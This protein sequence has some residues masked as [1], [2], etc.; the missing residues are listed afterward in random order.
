MWLYIVQSIVL[1]FCPKD[2][3]LNMKILLWNIKMHKCK[4]MSIQKLKCERHLSKIW[5]KKFY[6][7]RIIVRHVYF[8]AEKSKKRN[9]RKPRG[10][11]KGNEG[12][13]T[14]K[15]PIKFAA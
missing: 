14:R 12:F 9:W 11:F 1:T 4:F 3:R 7:K 8:C 2:K 13:T 5:M 10:R 6:N 15:M